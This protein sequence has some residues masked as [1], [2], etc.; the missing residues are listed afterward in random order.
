MPGTA[1]IG[2]AILACGFV[3]WLWRGLGVL[4]SG[5]LDPK[6][7]MFEWVSCVAY[8]LVAGLIARI[9]VAPSGLLAQTALADRL[10]ACLVALLAYHLARRNMFAGMVCGIAVFVGAGY[11]RGLIA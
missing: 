7:A 9:I 1:E 5:R 10:L 6:S 8:A 2:V 4:L 11:V 3:T